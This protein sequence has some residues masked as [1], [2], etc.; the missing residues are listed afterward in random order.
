MTS[1]KCA[2]IGVSQKTAA[3][4]PT[5]SLKGRLAISVSSQ[6]QLESAEVSTG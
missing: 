6:I 4:K 5:T 3:Y 1:H 2:L